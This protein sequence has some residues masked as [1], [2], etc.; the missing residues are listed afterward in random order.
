MTDRRS[1]AGVKPAEIAQTLDRGLQVL[2]M[3]A[4]VDGGLLPSEEAGQLGVHRTIAAR[5]HRHPAVPRVREQAARRPVRAVH[6]L[7]TLARQVSG[8]LLVVATPL[9]TEIAERLDAT[10]VLHVAHGDEAVSLASV[11]PRKATF[12]VGLRPGGRN[13]LTVAADGLAILAGRPAVEGER[14]EIAKARRRGYAVTT[15][16]L[17]PGFTG[18]SAPVIVGDWADASVGLVIPRTRRHDERALSD[19]VLAV[20]EKIA[21]SLV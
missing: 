7:V 12:T 5:L 18:I 19:E 14:P 6:T 17:V 11:E 9:L 8:D 20:A 10:A 1:G 21:Q 4:A 16:E 15:G 13:P 3:L 2:E